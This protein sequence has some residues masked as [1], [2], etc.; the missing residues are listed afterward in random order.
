MLILF[1]FVHAFL[2]LLNS[3]LKIFK[4]YSKNIWWNLKTQKD[5]VYLI[6]VYTQKKN[7]DYSWTSTKHWPGT[8][9][10][11]CLLEWLSHVSA[12][13]STGTET[14]NSPVVGPLGLA[15][16]TTMR[17]RFKSKTPNFVAIAVK[18]INWEVNGASLK[19]I[20]FS[21]P[22]HDKPFDE[23]FEIAEEAE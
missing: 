18:S 22:L 11:Y 2:L 7:R 3:K 4:K 13:L 9:R 21:F 15:S 12:Q 19:L 8:A 10:K 6:K 17:N 23:N 16:E 1:L 14:W 20:Y 5:F